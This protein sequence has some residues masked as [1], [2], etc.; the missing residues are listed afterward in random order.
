[1]KVVVETPKYSFFKYNKQ[2]KKITGKKKPEEPAEDEAI[3][4]CL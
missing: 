4:A 2:E 1:M 3:T